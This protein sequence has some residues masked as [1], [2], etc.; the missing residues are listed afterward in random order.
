MEVDA[1]AAAEEA[2]PTTATREQQLE[3]WA[4][5]YWKDD[6]YTDDPNALL[7]LTQLLEDTGGVHHDLDG[8]EKALGVPLP[9]LLG[10]AFES[11]EESGDDRS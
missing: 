9:S 5:Q 3:T 6:G 1:D 11:S 7:A 8:T 4:R 2:P 10:R